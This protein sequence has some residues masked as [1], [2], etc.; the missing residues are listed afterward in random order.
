VQI[1]CELTVAGETVHAETKDLSPGGAAVYFDRP[2]TVGEVI[3]VSFFLTQDGIED[4]ERAPFECAASV[5]W[6]RPAG[7]RHEAGV[8]FL[9]P[10]AGQRALLE[11]FL[12]QA[13]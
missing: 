11:D 9:S 6:T 7:G 8:Q 2:L 1:S 10:S 5:R 12:A 13:A 3:T 4:P